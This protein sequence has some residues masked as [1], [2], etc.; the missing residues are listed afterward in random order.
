MPFAPT[1][2]NNRKK[3][4][5]LVTGN[6]MLALY[7]MCLKL[8]LLVIGCLLVAIAMSAAVSN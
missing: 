2:N 7:A 5:F 1:L 8:K 6:D 4:I 3:Y